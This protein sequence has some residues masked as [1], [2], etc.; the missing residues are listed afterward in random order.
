MESDPNHLCDVWNLL[1]E[2]FNIGFEFDDAD[3]MFHKSFLEEILPRGLFLG[4]GQISLYP[5]TV[6]N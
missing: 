6:I 1:K 5:P 2:L 3:R 4:F